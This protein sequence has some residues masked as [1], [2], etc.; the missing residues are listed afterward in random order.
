M[1]VQTG[2][3]TKA[4]GEVVSD[5]PAVTKM[6]FRLINPTDDGFLKRIEWNKDEL[7]AAV[8]AKIAEY[9]DVVYTEDNI[10]QAKADR[11]E[12][13]KLVKAIEDRRKKVKTI[14]NAPYATFEKE[15]KEIT[16]LILEPVKMIDDQVKGYEEKQKEEKKEKI[17][18][19]YEEVI[20]ENA[21]NLPFERVFENQYL[22]ATFSLS[23]ATAEV[24]EKV[25]CFITDLETI[26]GLDSKFK[27]NVR[28]VYIQTLNLSKAMAENKRLLELEA[29][30]EEDKRRKEEEERKRK[31]E[32]ERKKAETQAKAS[33]DA[34]KKYWE[35]PK[36][37]EVPAENIQKQ[38][39][40]E[41]EP[42]VEE[43]PKQE[44]QNDA[45][46]Q[47]GVIDPFAQGLPAEEQKFKTRFYAIGTKEQLAGLVEYM[48][49][50]NI[51]YGKVEK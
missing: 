21:D 49:Q 4:Q 7:E 14:V 3:V 39:Q 22:N 44:I 2:V 27:L 18:A 30:M 41:E 36:V 6:E 23:K 43:E 5:V 8:R 34:R 40:K 35:Q 24:K 15:L 13:N 45:Q 31:E 26:D 29:K 48:K 19:A 1:S 47:N 25:K 20:G 12:L 46:A 11:A 17:K 32:A 38:E 33:E 37:E 42:K 28:D 10:K 51:Q 9:E 16:A 50:N